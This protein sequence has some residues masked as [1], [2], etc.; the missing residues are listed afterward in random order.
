MRDARL[1][2]VPD[3]T[4]RPLFSRMDVA[5]NI[6]SYGENMYRNEY[7]LG[8][9]HAEENAIRKLPVLPRKNRLKKVDMLV[10][11]TNR[12]GNLGSSRPCKNC[13]CHMA[14]KLPEKGYALQRVYYS[15]TGGM[16]HYESFH[17][18]V[19]DDN[20]HVTR[21]YKSHGACEM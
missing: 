1:S 18:L 5:F 14:T 7:F 19:H 3:S 15:D 2:W 9:S 10:I 16:I 4:T 8:T 6:L 21:Y 12:D 20:C 13:I 11:R 17:K